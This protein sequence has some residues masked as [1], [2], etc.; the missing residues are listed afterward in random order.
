[1]KNPLFG[2]DV[3]MHKGD[4]TQVVFW[5]NDLK[6]HNKCTRK[7]IGVLTHASCEWLWNLLP[8]PNSIVDVWPSKDYL[9]ID[10]IFHQ[11]AK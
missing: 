1:M 11:E 4:N 8:P 5:R 2:I 7:V 3:Q 9:S 6:H 10:F